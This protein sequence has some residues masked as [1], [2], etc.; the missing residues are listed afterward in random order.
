MQSTDKKRK[1]LLRSDTGLSIGV[2]QEET[3]GIL[4]AIG[5]LQ[6][7][8]KFITQINKNITNKI[9]SEQLNLVLA[10]NQPR[11]NR[12]KKEFNVRS[13]LEYPPLINEPTSPNLL[14]TKCLEHQDISATS[15]LGTIDSPSDAESNQNFPLSQFGLVKLKDEI[16]DN[17]VSQLNQITDKI[18]DLSGDLSLGNLSNYMLSTKGSKYRVCE[19][20]NQCIAYNTLQD[21]KMSVKDS[22]F[23]HLRKL[24]GNHRDLAKYNQK[25]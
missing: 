1:N 22:L 5:M 15:N 21:P 24:Q 3:H 11:Q 23:S 12:I 20:T 16:L 13:N 17:H 10:E 8:P 14:L 9:R 7:R 19:A 4:G 18:D 6:T 2:A 25:I